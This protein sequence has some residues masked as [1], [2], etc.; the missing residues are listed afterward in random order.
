MNFFH[1]ECQ[2]MKILDAYGKV[3]A[4][5]TRLPI[6]EEIGTGAARGLYSSYPSQGLRPER[7][8]AIFTEADQGDILRQ[9]ELFQEMEEKDAHLASVLQTRKLAVAGLE[10]EIAAASGRREDEETASFVQD[11]LQRVENW[12][13]ALMDMLD[14]VSKGFSVSELMWEIDPEA[15]L[16]RAW[17]R[18]IRWRHPGMFTFMT[19]PD[20]PGAAP[21]FPRLLTEAQ[22]VY[23]EALPASKFLV[24][25]YRGRSGIAPRA[26]ILR[27]CA[28]MYL[29]K[30]YTIKDWVIFNERFA[31]PMRVGKFTAGA[32]EADRRTLRNAVFNLGADAAAVI[33]DSTVIELLEAQ[34]KGS[35]ADVYEKLVEFCDRSVTKAVLG[36]AG[37]ADSTPGRLGSEHEARE[38]RRDIL[39]ADAKALAKTLTM[40]LIRPLVVFN[41][42]VGRR[43]PALR[44]HH[45]ADED[46]KALA[47]TYGTLVRDVGFKAIPAS[48]IHNRF[49][50]P[51][52]ETSGD[53]PSRGGCDA[54]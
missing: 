40:Q 45:E 21:D 35:S 52:P 25:R 48:H 2:E 41:F 1:T 7:L 44:F 31:M 49:G 16:G 36:H 42:G 5:T 50:I 32:S 29:F 33:S 53:D 24:H 20:E 3:A 43:V 12:D 23:G 4:K 17:V 9:A 15:G 10:Y 8:A 6:L 54:H 27:P 11:A 39:E 19:H 22:P 14:A 47:E 13:E 51:L 46:L 38:V 37:S 18:E 34:G 26:G 28:Y 30:N